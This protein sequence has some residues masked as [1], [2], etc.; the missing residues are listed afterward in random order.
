LGIPEDKAKI[1]SDRVGNGSYLIMVNGTNDDIS[2]AER[3][4]HNSGIEEYNVYDANDINDDIYGRTSG[5]N[6]VNTNQSATTMG[7]I[8]RS[9]VIE[10]NTT[11]KVMDT[12]TEVNEPRTTSDRKTTGSDADVIIIEPR[13]NQ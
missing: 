3:I 6:R 1:Y 9:G 7:D 4:L 2:R 11:S 8:D 10:P 5:V 12:R 13:D